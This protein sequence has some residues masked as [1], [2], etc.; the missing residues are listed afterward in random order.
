MMLP[1]AAQTDGA[2]VTRGFRSR[3]KE[4]LQTLERN[5]PKKTYSRKDKNFSQRRSS[6]WAYSISCTDSASIAIS[7]ADVTKS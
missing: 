3:E 2:Y 4:R 1:H 7:G 6:R 5:G